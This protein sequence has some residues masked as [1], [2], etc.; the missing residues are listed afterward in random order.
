MAQ[1]SGKTSERSRDA[2]E[3][4][5]ANTARAG[6]PYVTFQPE[7]ALHFALQ[8]HRLNCLDEA[9]ILYRRIL[10]L[11]PDNLDALHFLGLLCHQQRRNEEAAQLMRRILE[12][13]PQNFDAH[14]NLG[15]V[16]QAMG[17]FPEA[18]S[19]YRRAISL[20]PSHAP[21]HNN[22]GVALSAQKKVVEAIQSHR[23][24][25]E[26]AQDSADYFFNLGNALRRAGEID[27]SLDSYRKAIALA[28]EHS[29]ARQ[30]LAR[31]LARIG[32]RDEAKD[33]F[34]EW[35]RLD[36]AN[37]VMH[38]LRAACLETE[39]PVRA[40]DAYI[41]GVFDNMAEE[42]ET[43]LMECLDYRAPD[44]IHDALSKMLPPPASDLDILDAGC[45]TGLCAPFLRPFARRLTGVDISGNM[46]R[47][48]A[49]R[50]LYDDL[51]KS[52]L[53][54]FLA[55]QAERFDVVVSADTLCYFGEL[56]PVFHGAAG[57]L[58]EGGILAFTLEDSGEGGPDVRLTPQCRYVHSRPYI[59]LALESAGFSVCSIAPTEL[60]KESKEPVKGHLVIARKQSHP[61]P[62]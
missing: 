30:L 4:G 6:Q 58:K 9:E 57:A 2:A 56:A 29:S 59:E 51:I 33:V 11:F 16:F 5:V 37:Q 54:E 20:R 27:E 48:A 14:N 13:D 31:T 7:E 60:R 18:E 32:R 41:E 19:C 53:T 55:S 49:G 15:N 12:S 23:R 43:H 50:G 21:A 8:F 25:V 28:P 39:A 34:E 61:I 46:L 36:P 40:P 3:E 24:A 62:V 44:L 1:Q 26:L 52:E 47:K 45:G 22:L 17:A 10:Q 35:L 38:Y 42:F